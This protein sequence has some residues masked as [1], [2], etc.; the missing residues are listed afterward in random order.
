[1]DILLESEVIVSLFNEPKHSGKAKRAG[2]NNLFVHRLF[3]NIVE[4]FVDEA[5][6]H[7]VG[8]KQNDKIDRAFFGV[9]IVTAGDLLYFFLDV[10]TEDFGEIS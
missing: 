10:A 6:D 7:L 5:K 2:Q 9:N 8:D 3:P 1:M 4:V